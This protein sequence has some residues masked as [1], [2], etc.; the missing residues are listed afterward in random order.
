MDSKAT[1][2]QAFLIG[3][4]DDIATEL[5]S[6][7]SAANCELTADADQAEIVFCPWDHSGFARTRARFPHAP[8]VVVSDYP[9][10]NGWLDALEAGAADY[11]AAPFEAIQLRW[12][13]DAHLRPSRRAFAAA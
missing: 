2:N 7:L 4:R 13:L 10:V 6:V 1:P 8:V 12:I 3:I 9:D 11:C 5:K